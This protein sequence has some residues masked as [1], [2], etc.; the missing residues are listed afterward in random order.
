MESSLSDCACTLGISTV[1]LSINDSL[2]ISSIYLKR[3][4]I[5]MSVLG[6]SMNILI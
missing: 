1:D 3:Y 6:L 5:V 4:V 2:P